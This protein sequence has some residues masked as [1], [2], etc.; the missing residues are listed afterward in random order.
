VTTLDLGLAT[1]RSAA[2]RVTSAW[3][4]LARWLKSLMPTGLYSRALLS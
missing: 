4:A 1:L 3:D 2:G